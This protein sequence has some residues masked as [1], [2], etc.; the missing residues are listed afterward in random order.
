MNCP[1]C[2]KPMDD[3]LGLSKTWTCIFCGKIIK[4]KKKAK[5][6]GIIPW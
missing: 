4:K 2:K 6:G 3:T 1:K 5:T